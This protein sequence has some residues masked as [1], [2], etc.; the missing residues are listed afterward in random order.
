MTTLSTIS[1]FEKL[2]GGDVIAEMYKSISFLQTTY[3]F[4]PES[5]FYKV[6]SRLSPDLNYVEYQIDYHDLDSYNRWY[7]LFGEIVEELVAEF[8][9]EFGPLNIKYQ[10]YLDKD[11]TL[12]PEDSL[13]LEKFTSRF[14]FVEGEYVYNKSEN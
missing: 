12:Q 6:E 7:E 5:E 8:I 1:T 10:R 4:P 9:K 13:P 2:D 14:T 11:I 3:C